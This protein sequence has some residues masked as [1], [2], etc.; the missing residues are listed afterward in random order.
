MYWY[1]TTKWTSFA[2]LSGIILC[3]SACKPDIKETGATLK[4]FDLKGFFEADIAHLKKLK[5]TVSKTVMHN[6]AS[7]NKKVKIDNWSQ[8]LNLFMD[9]DINKPAWQNSYSITADS[10]F[11]IYQ[12]KDPALKMLEMVIMRDKQKVKWILIYNH[13][14]NMLYTTTE[15]LTYYPDSVYLIEKQQHVRLRGNNFYRIEGVIQH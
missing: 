11:I 14:T 4:Y 12:S 15:K 10:S 9:A 7:E 1:K 3:C 5:P 6:G 2:L 13:T 8:E